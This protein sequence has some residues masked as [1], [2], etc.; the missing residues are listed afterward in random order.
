MRLD[1]LESEAETVM[2]EDDGSGD[3]TRELRKVMENRKKNQ[4]KQ[5]NPR[6]HRYA[7]D[8]R[9][10]VRY[11][12][13][14]NS[15]ISPTT[16]TDPDAATPSSTK[17]GTTRCVCNNSDGDGLMIQWYAS[18]YALFLTRTLLTGAANLVITGFTLNA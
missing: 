17:S 3:A 16:V 15:N 18:Y 12:S 1:G 7:S 6:H 13:S 5:R 11:Y 8:S 14:S 2:E 10:G 9:G 4:L